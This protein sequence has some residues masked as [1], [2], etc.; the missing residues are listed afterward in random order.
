MLDSDISELD[1]K[2]TAYDVVEYAD[3][4]LCLDFL[5]VADYML[6]RGFSAD[7]IN[8]AMNLQA[9]TKGLKYA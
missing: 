9:G 4:E 8:T 2:T 5:D 6:A 7:A 3:T 1:G